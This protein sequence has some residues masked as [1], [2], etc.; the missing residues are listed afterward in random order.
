MELGGEGEGRRDEIPILAAI[1]QSV[2]SGSTRQEEM[3]DSGRQA[4]GVGG[5]VVG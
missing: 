3:A 5:R 2:D 4:M 1:D